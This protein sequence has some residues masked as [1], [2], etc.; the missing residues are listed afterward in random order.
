MVICFETGFNLGE[1]LVPPLTYHFCGFLSLFIALSSFLDHLYVQTSW[2]ERMGTL[3][4]RD[5]KIFVRQSCL[6]VLAHSTVPAM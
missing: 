6:C 4:P 2:E 1:G 5:I 3:Y